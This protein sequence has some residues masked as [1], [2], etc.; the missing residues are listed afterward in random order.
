MSGHRID[1]DAFETNKLQLHWP[2]LDKPTICISP[3][4]MARIA[5]AEKLSRELKRSHISLW[6]MAIANLALTLYYVFTQHA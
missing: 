5:A 2:E 3:E 4:L 1:I 6:L